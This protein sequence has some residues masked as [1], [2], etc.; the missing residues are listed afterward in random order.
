[1]QLEESRKELADEKASRAAEQQAAAAAQQALT[2]KAEAAEAMASEA[3][4]MTAAAEARA[5]AAEAAAAGARAEVEAAKQ[6]IARIQ[7]V[8]EETSEKLRESEAFAAKARE[9]VELLEGQIAALEER[10][11][12]ALAK[13]SALEEEAANLRGALEGAQE[14]ARRDEETIAGLQ[15]ELETMREKIAGVA[16]LEA[17]VERMKSEAEALGEQLR[18]SATE[19]ER[20]REAEGERAAEVQRLQDVVEELTAKCT[21]GAEVLQTTKK[22]LETLQKLLD[23]GDADAAFQHKVREIEAK[24]EAQIANERALA[25]ARE[26]E[27][28][29]AALSGLT[30]LREH[31]VSTLT[32]M[33]EKDRVAPLV[34]IPLADKHA[35]APAAARPPKPAN[36]NFEWDERKHRWAFVSPLQEK[37][38]LVSAGP[39][40]NIE[41]MHASPMPPRPPNGGMQSRS[42]GPSPRKVR[43]PL[44]PSHFVAPPAPATTPT[45]QSPRLPSISSPNSVVGQPPVAAEREPS[46]KRAG[47]Q[48]PNPGKLHRRTAAITSVQLHLPPPAPVHEEQPTLWF[49]ESE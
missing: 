14:K 23:S 34:E 26:Q 42:Q 29:S 1:M 32:G 49:H 33:R 27:L 21:A 38:T 36:G 9:Q 40:L 45:G 6:E 18:A 13:V 46:F 3:K 15:T 17:E 25:K 19:L 30:H 11:A 48:A 8:L 12:A 4:A 10:E 39:M 35:A 37:I 44:E 2:E 16:R 43:A 41:S 31:L 7:A 28:V 20:A 47:N 24:S 5:E 22:Q